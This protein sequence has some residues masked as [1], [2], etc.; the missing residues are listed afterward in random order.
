MKVGVVFT[1]LSKV[2]LG[3]LQCFLDVGV[4]DHV[5][6]GTS[7]HCV[8]VVLTRSYNLLIGFVI[9]DPSVQKGRI[10]EHG[11]TRAVLESYNVV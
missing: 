11:L 2:L 10:L 5:E 4:G 7:G 8:S 6:S 1:R 9:F 3:F